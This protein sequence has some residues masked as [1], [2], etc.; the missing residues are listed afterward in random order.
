MEN[1]THTHD[2]MTSESCQNV[3][4]YTLILRNCYQCQRTWTR[5]L[6]NQDKK[7]IKDLSMIMRYKINCKITSYSFGLFVCL[8]ERGSS[9]C[10]VFFSLFVF[11]LC[12][13]EKRARAY[14][15]DARS[16]SPPYFTLVVTEIYRETEFHVTP[17]VA[18]SVLSPRREMGSVSYGT[19]G[20]L[21][22]ARSSRGPRA[23]QLGSIL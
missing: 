2:K 5:S 12:Y 15:P 19:C 21:L 9:V 13:V 20:T 14:S 6:E 23:P 4:V 1:H 11:S 7:Y 18:L 22:G 16:S 17:L 3:C 10:F 8:F